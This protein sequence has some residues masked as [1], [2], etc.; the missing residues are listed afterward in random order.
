M[1]VVNSGGMVVS[2]IVYGDVMIINVMVC[3][4][5][6]CRVFFYSGGIVN[7]VRVMVIMLIE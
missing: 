4:N 7:M 2:M 3:S 5:V 6:C 1:I